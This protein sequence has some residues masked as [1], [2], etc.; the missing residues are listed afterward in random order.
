MKKCGSVWLEIF[1]TDEKIKNYVRTH[2]PY[3]WSLFKDSLLAK[4]KKGLFVQQESTELF[5]WFCNQ[6]RAVGWIEE[7]RDDEKVSNCWSDLQWKNKKY[8]WS[9]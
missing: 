2:F 9:T 4:I 1:Q 3:S 7:A 5:Y 6:P 8:A